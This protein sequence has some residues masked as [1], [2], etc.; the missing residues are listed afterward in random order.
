MVKLADMWIREKLCQRSQWGPAGCLIPS[1]Q[2]N[3]PVFETSGALS[4]GANSNALLHDEVTFRN[5][6]LKASQST[7]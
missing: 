4:A 2:R 7:S 1:E 6:F 5:S 3:A